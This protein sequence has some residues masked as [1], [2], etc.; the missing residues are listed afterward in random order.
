LREQQLQRGQAIVAKDE[1]EAI[2]QLLDFVFRP[3]RR[4]VDDARAESKS[5]SGKTNGTSYFK[6]CLIPE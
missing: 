5:N 6:A 4:D 1:V 3:I 2:A